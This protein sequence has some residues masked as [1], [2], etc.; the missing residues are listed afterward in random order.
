MNAQHER[1]RGSPIAREVW[2]RQYRSGGWDYLT[3]DDEAGHYQAIAEFYERHLRDGSLLDIGCGTGILVAYL[4]W[5]AGMEPSRYTG[6][7]LAQD[8]VDQAQSSCPG[9]R[10]SR[11]D[12]STDAVPGR[13]D[14][15]IF[16]ETLYCFDDPVAMVDKSITENM[17]A[18]SLLIVSMYGDHHEP[19][20]DAIATR[21]DTVDEQAVENA[22]GV[23]W[24]IQVLRPRRPSSEPASFR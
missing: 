18:D 2:E 9:G 22:R 14:G 11:L 13:F 8:A 6:I 3:G 10:F 1:I 7:D 16:N 5:H 23:C 17:H 4:Q 24:K 15:V 20:W 12:Y 21:C 19:I